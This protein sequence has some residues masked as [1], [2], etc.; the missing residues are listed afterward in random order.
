VW[1][2]FIY[3]SEEHVTSVYRI[4]Y[5]ENRSSNLLRKVV[6]YLT[7]GHGVTSVGTATWNR[8]KKV[9]LFGLLNCEG[10]GATSVNVWPKTRRHRPEDSNIQQFG[11]EN[12]RK[13]GVSCVQTD[14]NAI[15]YANSVMCLEHEKECMMNK[16]RICY[17]GGS[18][19][20]GWVEIN[21]YIS[22]FGL[23]W[24]C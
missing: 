4:V 13:L 24:W 10:R 12:R 19:K 17:K 2:G 14:G 6:K 7:N 9:L 1:Y 16:E 15:L 21:W 22:A 20:P 18:G 8:P 5:H 23:C 3:A 11:C